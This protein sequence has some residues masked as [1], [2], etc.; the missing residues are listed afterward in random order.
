MSAGMAAVGRWLLGPFAYARR[1]AAGAALL[2]LAVIVLTALTQVGGLILWL[3]LPLLG[4]AY[5]WG[6]GP[7]PQKK[8][9]IEPRP[10][11]GYSSLWQ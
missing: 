1:S 9:R 6:S 5:R 11:F 4:S 2:L 7:E 3:F 10:A 8:Q